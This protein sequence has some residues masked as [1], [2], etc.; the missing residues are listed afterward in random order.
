[1]TRLVALVLALASITH[2]GTVMPDEEL[3]EGIDVSHYQG[4]IDWPKVRNDGIVFAIM[5]AT[6]GLRA[7]DP[8]FK[9]N[10]EAS[11]KAGLSR[12]AYH[13]LEPD[14]DGTA[15]AQHFLRTVEFTKGD[16]I[17]AVDVERKG[18]ALTRTLKDFLAEVKK[19]LGVDA[20]IYVSPSFWNEH[21]A[22]AFEEPLPNPLWIAEYDV[23]APKTTRGIGPWLVWQY[24]KT[25]R[26]DGIA[27]PVDRDRARTLTGDHHIR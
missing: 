14:Q 16:L 25:G 7:V 3:V 22:D 11:K 1:M 9:F 15:Q 6:Q 24:S 12:G 20:V 4:R 19:S 10:W 26:V 18:E 8:R 23:S 21:L 2:F 17:P 13:F 5:K 27:G